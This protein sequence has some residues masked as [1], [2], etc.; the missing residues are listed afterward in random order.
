MTKPEAQAEY[1]S[2]F[3]RQGVR[4][5]VRMRGFMVRAGGVRHPV[6]LTDLHYGGCGIETPIDLVPGEDIQLSVLGRGSIPAAVRWCKD[7]RAGL[8]FAPAMQEEKKEVERRSARIE[9]PGKVAL[10][11]PGKTACRVRVHDLSTDGCKVELVERPSVG[12][13]MHVK[14]EG[15]ETLGADVCW[16]VGHTAGLKFEHAIH[17]AVFG[18]LLERLAS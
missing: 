8:D 5:P 3:D 6:Q 14:F 17:P 10:H 18:L 9:V 7:G 13:K 15:L 4:R 1:I 12:D 2:S 16:V 11:A